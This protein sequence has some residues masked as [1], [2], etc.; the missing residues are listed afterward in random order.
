MLKTKRPSSIKNR[1]RAVILLTSFA[2]VLATATAFAVYEVINFRAQLLRNLGTLAAVMADNSAAPLSFENPSNAEEILAALRA[3]PDIVAA[4]LYDVNGDLFARYP[5]SLPVT[6]LPERIENETREFR[7]G[8]VIL[9]TTIELENKPVGT[10]YLRSS[11]SGLHDRLWRFTVILGAVLAASFFGALLLSTFLQRRIT[12]PILALTKAARTVSEREDYSVRAPCLTDDEL[13]TLTDAFNRMLGQTQEHQGRLAEQARLLDLSTDAITV[14]DMSGHLV[15]WNRGAE[16]LYGWTEAEALGQSDAELL[17][18]EYPEPLERINEILRQENRWSGDLVQTRRDGQPLHVST[19]WNMVRDQ[20][21]HAARVL[22][23]DSDIS[24]RKQAED[25]MKSEASRLDA[26]VAQRTAK[27]QETIGE[28]E[29]FSYSVSHDMR[30]P[31]RAMQGYAT[32]LLDDFKGQIDP[33][34]TEY[35][36]RIVRASN[37]LDALVRDV[38]A[39][40]R[41]AKDDIPLHAVDLQSLV[42]DILANQPE[43]QP[44]RAEIHVNQP[45]PPV[46]GHEACLTQCVS[47]LLANAVKFVPAG[48]IPVIRV[49]GEQLD[50]KVR[51]WFEDNG[52]GIDPAHQERIFQIFGQVYPEKKYGGTGIGLAIVRKAAQRMNGEVGV[53]STLGQGSRFWIVLNG[54][55]DEPNAAAR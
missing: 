49:R 37:R 43:F 36:A 40:S 23:I 1:V 39:Y 13:G 10:L 47:N 22:A 46:L 9:F 6:L 8:A 7:D 42:E 45:L 18:T 29:A 5:A 55:T 53:E 38:L 24:A 17:R 41:V 3:E 25:L 32:A 2:V 33:Q 4:A 12:E 26:L 35:L 31:L 34:A 52:I 27:L 44:P 14:R 54:I 20:R 50:G 15:Y 30:A 16:E 11:L 48:Q 51:L 21:G 19:R 28:L